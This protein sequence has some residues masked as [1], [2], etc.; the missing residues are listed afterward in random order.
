MVISEK[1]TVSYT[2]IY[3]KRLLVNLSLVFWIKVEEEREEKCNLF[4]FLEGCSFL[5]ISRQW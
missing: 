1:E 4:L 2:Y 3:T 5:G